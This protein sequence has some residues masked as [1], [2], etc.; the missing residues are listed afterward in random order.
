[1][2]LA[3]FAGFGARG[4]KGHVYLTTTAPFPNVILRHT[5]VL[6]VDMFGFFP[7]VLVIVFGLGALLAGCTDPQKSYRNIGPE[8]ALCDRLFQLGPDNA[9]RS[10][11]DAKAAP[12][13][14]QEHQ[15]P[16]PKVSRG[17]DATGDLPLDWAQMAA[18]AGA[19][20]QGADRY[21]LSFVEMA[22]SGVLHR[23]EQLDNL[24]KHLQSEAG[25]GRQNY[26]FTFV[27][28][29]RHDAAPGDRDVKKFRVLLGYTRSFL[30]TRCVERGEYCNASLTG[31]FVSWRGRAFAEPVLAAEGNFNPLALLAA[32][33]FFGRKAQ[34]E[35]HASGQAPLLD[36]ILARIEANLKLDQANPRA[37]KML[38]FGHSFGGNMLATMLEARAIKAIKA[39]P[40]GNASGGKVMP[41]LAGDMVVLINPASEA[42]KWTSLQREMRATFG[43]DDADNYITAAKNGATDPTR[44]RHLAAWRRQ[45]PQSQRPTYIAITSTDNWPRSKLARALDF[46]TP[47]GVFFPFAQGLAGKRSPEERNTIGHLEPRYHPDTLNILDGPPVGTTHELSVNAKPARAARYRHASD[48]DLAWCDAANGWLAQVRKDQRALGWSHGDAWDY[49]LTYAEAEQKLVAAENIARGRNPASVQWRHG[50][51]TAAKDGLWSVVPGNAPFWNVRTKD[52]AVRNHAGYQNYPLWCALNQLVLDDVTSQRILDENVREVLQAEEDFD[53]LVATGIATPQ[54]QIEPER[55]PQKSLLKLIFNGAQKSQVLK[56]DEPQK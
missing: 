11:N 41:P 1:V 38:I 24:A 21:H 33:T 10:G 48:P 18:Q 37:D 19:P 34:S 22:D 6:G 47:T 9:E 54:A 3:P 23:P 50:L 17:A 5:D 28:G 52:N 45:F 15:V 25:A 40:P 39:H 31:V 12:C 53:A 8:N 20:L 4:E 13:Y 26:V 14:L 2:V 56:S 44:Y 55:A 42:A 29:W 16:A 7:R 46:D 51:N 43:M 35:A 49:G 36:K 32:P 30:N 27:H